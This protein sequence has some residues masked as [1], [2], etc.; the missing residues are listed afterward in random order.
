MTP[1]F[2][3]SKSPIL[4]VMANLPLTFGC[5]K[6]FQVIKPPVFF[7]L[8]Q[9]WR[10]REQHMD[11]TDFTDENLIMWFSAHFH[12]LSFSSFLSG[13]WSTVSLRALPF[14]HS[15]A[16]LSPTLPTTS[17]MPSLRSATVEVLPGFIRGATKTS[18]KTWEDEG[19]AEI[20]SCAPT[21]TG[22]ASHSHLH[23]TTT[24]TQGWGESRTEGTKAEGNTCRLHCFSRVYQQQYRETKM[25][26]DPH[27]PAMIL[28][29]KMQQWWQSVSFAC[30]D[31]GLLWYLTVM[32]SR[33][34]YLNW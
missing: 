17:S 24:W 3:R 27:E 16:R 30:T 26:S 8:E 10:E 29:F 5:P 20:K 19:G 1:I 25:I 7:I 23:E 12:Y 31:G 15:M 22:C 18:K 34:E 13:V 32:G 28:R 2:F 4:R 21:S 14:R 33:D 9:V 11:Q 6:L